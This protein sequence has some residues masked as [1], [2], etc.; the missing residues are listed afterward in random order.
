MDDRPNDFL[1][2]EQPAVPRIVQYRQRRYSLRME[3]IFWQFLEQIARDHNTKLGR[4]VA[5][6]AESATG[7]NLTSHIRAFCMFQAEQMV[8]RLATAA[9]RA[10]VAT[11]VGSCP[12]PGLVLS[13]DR[14]IVLVNEALSAWLGESHPVLVGAELT[15]IF[16]VRTQRPL[17]EIWAGMVSGAV[18]RCQAKFVYV[19]PGR[20]LAAEARLMGYHSRRREGFACIAWLAPPGMM[21]TRRASA[22]VQA[23][24]GMRPTPI[25]GPAV[26]AGAGNAAVAPAGSSRDG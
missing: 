20:V 25:A 4:L 10:H 12:A 21:P 2:A 15:G 9:G 17:N 1:F 8:A 26:T 7:K 19:A 23:P 16:Q 14:R 3:K 18:P 24:A 11:L 6:L 22:A 5:A 13:R